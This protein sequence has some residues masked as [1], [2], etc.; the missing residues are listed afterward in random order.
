MKIYGA[1]SSKKR[2]GAA[3]I[4]SDSI[5][6]FLYEGDILQGGE[7]YWSGCISLGESDPLACKA[8]NVRSVNSLLALIGKVAGH[9]VHYDPDDVRS[10]R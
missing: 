7:N 10:R 2:N 4:R 9:I 1:T 3:T 8:I 5:S 6:L